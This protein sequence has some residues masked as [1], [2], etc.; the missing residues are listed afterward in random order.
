[1]LKLSEL[2]NVPWPVPIR[3]VPKALLE[4]P[5]FASVLEDLGGLIECASS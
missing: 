1:M 2:P 3:E 5:P 4:H